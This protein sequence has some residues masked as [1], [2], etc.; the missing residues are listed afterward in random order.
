MAGYSD[1]PLA[2]KLG[3]KAGMVIGLVQAPADWAKKVGDAAT[4]IRI[5]DDPLVKKELIL[6]FV[7]DA[8]EPISLLP[9]LRNDIVQN[10]MIWVCWVKKSSKSLKSV[11]DENSIRSAA[12]SS[13]LVDVKVCAYDEDWS[14]L[15]LVIRLKDRR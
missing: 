13:G 8:A 14:A 12:L 5:T 15:K 11:T 4:T 10:G 2:K 3:L 9:A 6:Y 1:A 7:T